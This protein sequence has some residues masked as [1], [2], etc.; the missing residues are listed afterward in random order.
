MAPAKLEGE[1]RGLAYLVL[2]ATEMGR[3]MYEK[4]GWQHSAEMGLHLTAPA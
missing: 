4:L 1:R 2:H 3:P